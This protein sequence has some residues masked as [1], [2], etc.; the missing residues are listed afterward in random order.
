MELLI[1]PKES[2]SRNGTESDLLKFNIH[3]RSPISLTSLQSTLNALPVK[4][5]DRW[6]Q[7]RF[8]NALECVDVYDCILIS[9]YRARRERYRTA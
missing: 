2:D 6:D 3:S 1:A 4:V 8:V 5:R 7:F 9:L